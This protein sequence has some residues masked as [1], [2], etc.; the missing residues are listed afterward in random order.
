MGGFDEIVDVT[1]DITLEVLSGTNE[2]MT[3][4]PSAGPAITDVPVLF[5]DDTSVQNPLTQRAE[6]PSPR[7]WFKLAD[8]APNDPRTDEPT[9]TILGQ[10]Y[11]I[12][13]RP[14]DGQIGNTIHLRLHEIP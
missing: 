8:I 3:Y 9:I 5:D 10:D 13:Q 2:L 1:D 14:A 6:F 4:V 11:R 12:H 7:V